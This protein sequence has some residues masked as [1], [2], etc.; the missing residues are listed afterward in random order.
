M[1]QRFT[2]LC[3][4][5]TDRL[6]MVGTA[7]HRRRGCITAVGK[8]TGSSILRT[9]RQI[10]SSSG[11]RGLLFN[12][13]QWRFYQPFVRV[14]PS[15]LRVETEVM[16]MVAFFT[17]F[18]RK[19][20]IHL[21]ALV[22]LVACL[23]QLPAL[24]QIDTGA[25]SPIT[26][27]NAAD[28][29]QIASYNTR[30]DSL[31]PRYVLMDVQISEATN[32]LVSYYSE[33][34]RGFD[35]LPVVVSVTD[36]ASGQTRFVKVLDPFVFEVSLSPQ[37]RYLGIQ[38]GG[39]I[40][41]LDALSGDEV[42]LITDADVSGRW[43]FNPQDTRIAYPTDLV[44]EL[45]IVDIETGN[46]TDLVEDP[47]IYDAIFCPNIPCI[48]YRNVDVGQIFIW[49]LES[50]QPSRSIRYR[51]DDAGLSLVFMLSTD[52]GSFAVSDTLF[53]DYSRHLVTGTID[54]G[55]IERQALDEA[56]FWMLGR[57]YG[58]ILIATGDQIA[59]GER[60]FFDFTNG[61]SL[62]VMQGDDYLVLVNPGETLAI[63]TTSMSDRV[64]A[65]MVAIE[66]GERVLLISGELLDYDDYKET[67][68]MRLEETLFA[69]TYLDGRV[70]LFGVPSD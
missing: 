16:P 41:V 4:H 11:Q 62:G 7:Q 60:H 29:V 48:V 68:G 17:H 30:P 22:V 25:L 10:S 20:N 37:G 35:P 69:F 26:P 49:D 21:I 2:P 67:Y 51:D 57:E 38:I 61:K 39:E 58:D 63:M 12:Q 5:F 42:L 59:G 28:M 46:E 52:G 44:M 27:A 53:E 64:A 9:D 70:T 18:T 13:L 24:A 6:A 55:V 34:E 40:R 47:G 33:F 19:S 8:R 31:D 66:T 32:T 50:S 43:T 1:R 23:G 56:S 45:R 14:C 3:D 36:I 65:N 54:G 15:A